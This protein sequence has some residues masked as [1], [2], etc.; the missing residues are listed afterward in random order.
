MCYRFFLI[1]PTEKV[2]KLKLYL[3]TGSA[4]VIMQVSNT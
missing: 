3:A 1:N 2:N 4:F